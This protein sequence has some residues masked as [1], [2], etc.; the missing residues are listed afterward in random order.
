MHKL[1]AE[2]PP[3]PP[4]MARLP[5]DE[6]GYPVPFFVQWFDGKPDFRVADSTKIGLCYR[7]RLCWICGEKLGAFMSFVIGPVGAVNHTNSEPP[8]H[9][10]CAM[11]AVRGCPFMARP[12]MERREDDLT[13]HCKKEVAGWMSERNPGVM[14]VWTTRTYRG[15]DDGRGRLLFKVGDPAQVTWHREGRLAT[16]AECEESLD[17]GM[18]EL[19]ALCRSDKERAEQEANYRQLKKLFPTK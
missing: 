2:L 19:M 13:E 4:R 9:L 15:I 7:L 8:S 12:K 6:R 5:I 14:A 16:R 1:R 18:P 11:W 17:G 3:L 10:D